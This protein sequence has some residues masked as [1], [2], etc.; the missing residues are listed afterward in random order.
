MFTKFGRIAVLRKQICTNAKAFRSLSTAT[1]GC[2]WV[3]S[4]I[5]LH[6]CCQ[7]WYWNQLVLVHKVWNQVCVS[8]WTSAHTLTLLFLCRCIGGLCS[9]WLCELLFLLTRLFACVFCLDSSVCL[10]WISVLGWC[11][12]GWR[13]KATIQM[14][15]RFLWW[16][17][18]GVQEGAASW[19]ETGITEDHKHKHNTTKINP[20]KRWMGNNLGRFGNFQENPRLWSWDDTIIVLPANCTVS[21]NFFPRVQKNPDNSAHSQLGNHSKAR[22]TGCY[23]NHHFNTAL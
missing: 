11:A 15:R 19:H 8:R 6:N 14:E 22:I 16:C 21:T 2:P 9:V 20:M 12:E 7:S 13:D 10:F 3:V 18:V 23:Q 5:I 17:S 4:D 1:P